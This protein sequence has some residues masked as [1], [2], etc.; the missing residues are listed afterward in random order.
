MEISYL[1]G[2]KKCGGIK[3]KKNPEIW[4]YNDELAHILLN[5]LLT[6]L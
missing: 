3:V 5:A 2:G 4:R 6:I 1:Y